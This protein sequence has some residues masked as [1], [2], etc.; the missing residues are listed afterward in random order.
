MSKPSTS[1][2]HVGP[3]RV[4]LVFENQTSISLDLPSEWTIMDLR[5]EIQSR[6]NISICRQAITGWPG[7]FPSDKDKLSKFNCF[8]FKLYVRDA[9]PA[10]SSSR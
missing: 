8:E 10:G 9:T 7:T 4:K 1:N 6:T 3:V 2:N 5:K